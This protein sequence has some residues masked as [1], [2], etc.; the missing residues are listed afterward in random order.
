MADIISAT[1][2]F[3]MQEWPWADLG[4]R[5]FPIESHHL[6]E[7][8]GCRGFLSHNGAVNALC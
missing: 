8:V 1:P 2:Y 5:I 4:G 6:L 3:Q 7:A